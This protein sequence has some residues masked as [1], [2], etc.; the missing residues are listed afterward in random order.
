MDQMQKIVEN[1]IRIQQIRVGT[2]QNIKNT[3]AKVEN[4]HLETIEEIIKDNIRK[5]IKNLKN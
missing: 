2:P 1:T 4:T 3:G 5:N